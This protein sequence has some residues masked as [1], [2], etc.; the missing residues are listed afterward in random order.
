VKS[1]PSRS[2]DKLIF[3]GVKFVERAE[4][5]T[6]FLGPTRALGV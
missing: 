1:L 2:S 4:K 3:N 6:I 5:G